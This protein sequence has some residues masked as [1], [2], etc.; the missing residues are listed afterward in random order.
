[1]SD[2]PAM[3]SSTAPVKAPRQDRSRRTLGKIVDAAHDLLLEGGV[4]AVT[5]Q[6][7][8]Q[9][10]G[11]S[12]GSFYARFSGK[13]DLLRHL[14]ETVWADATQRWEE[15]LQEHDW[16]AL[17]LEETVARIVQLVLASGRGDEGARRAL[18]TREG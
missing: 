5:V 12:V 11:A 3:E 15:G 10:A 16:S 14:D 4:E 18:A 7:V 13:E 8:V 17:S 1:M 6:S 2:A 9:R